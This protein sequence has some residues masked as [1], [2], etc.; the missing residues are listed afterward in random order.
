MAPLNDLLAFF[1]SDRVVLIA[2][3][4]SALGLLAIVSRPILVRTYRNLRP[5]AV[6]G[7]DAELPPE[8]HRDSPVA[9]HLATISYSTLTSEIGIQIGGQLRRGHIQSAEALYCLWRSVTS[10]LD[11][12]GSGE[13][14]TRFHTAIV[15][16]QKRVERH[17]AIVER[18]IAA[19]GY[20]FG[21]NRGRETIL[22]HMLLMLAADEL[23]RECRDDF[24]FGEP[25]D[26]DLVRHAWH[27]G[28]SLKLVDEVIWTMRL[29]NRYVELQKVERQPTTVADPRERMADLVASV[30]RT[31]IE[32]G[33]RF[34]VN[35]D[36]EVSLPLEIRRIAAD[37][38]I[39]DCQGFLFPSSNV[40]DVELL[41]EQAADTG[42]GHR[43]VEDALQA[44]RRANRYVERDYSQFSESPPGANLSSN[45]R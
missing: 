33:F 15:D 8:E 45:G 24:I 41:L 31:I 11:A 17:T 37:Q 13:D 22:P 4:M 18:T 40:R 7:T 32:H 29:Q 14:W 20:S 26:L 9:P 42:L 28:Q 10:S 39:R 12:P 2:G 19:Y 3:F 25:K 43:L 38:I 21:G 27:S 5:Q 6:S 1:S 34:G 16:E 35:G 44:S 23:V 36:H 30:E